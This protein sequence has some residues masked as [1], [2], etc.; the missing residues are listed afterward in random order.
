MFE[1][2]IIHNSDA[3]AM[4]QIRKEFAAFQRDAIVQ[5]VESLALNDAE[6]EALFASL[7]ADLK[8]NRHKRTE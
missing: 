6:I 3:D 5:Y 4:A 8:I 7:S 2:A 1:K